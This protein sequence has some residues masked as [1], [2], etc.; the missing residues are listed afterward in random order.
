MSNIK[1][2]PLTGTSYY[3][4]D[5]VRFKNINLDPQNILFSINELHSMTFRNVVFQKIS[6]VF[7][8]FSIKHVIDNFTLEDC[9]FSDISTASIENLKKHSDII[10]SSYVGLCGTFIDSKL[11]F[12][13]VSFDTIHYNCLSL[14]NLD[15]FFNDVTIDYENSV[16]SPFSAWLDTNEV[17][18]MV[19]MKNIFYGEVTGSRFINN[20]F[21]TKKGAVIYY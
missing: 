16:I 12:N 19:I 21:K 11:F 14:A 18:P 20:K 3:L 10:E 5:N 8:L 2:V 17:G 1:N 7:M 15:F 13:N 6:N 9:Y 4:L